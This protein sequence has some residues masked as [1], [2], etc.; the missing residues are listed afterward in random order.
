MVGGPEVV[1]EIKVKDEHATLDG[2][3]LEN[4]RPQAMSNK[5][6]SGR[7]RQRE[8]A[9]IRLKRASC[10]QGLPLPLRTS[11]TATRFE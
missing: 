1:V 2:P 8:Q 5:S 9:S 3:V 11:M 10:V 7:E 6:T 4:R